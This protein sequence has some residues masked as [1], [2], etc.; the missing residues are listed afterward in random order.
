VNCGSVSYFLRP[1]HHLFVQR[2]AISKNEAPSMAIVGTSRFRSRNR[3]RIS[4]LVSAISRQ[5]WHAAPWGGTIRRCAHRAHDR[6]TRD[7][8][9]RLLRVPAHRG[10]WR[11]KRGTVKEQGISRNPAIRC[12]FGAP[13]ASEFNS[14]EVNSLRNGTG[15]FRTRIRENFSMNR[16]F[17][18]RNAWISNF[19]QPPRSGLIEQGLA[20][21]AR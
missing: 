9:S 3:F 13:S 11:A 18:T 14:L 7:R 20:G 2:V 1:A 16:E 21:P 17:S 4:Q 6:R 15:N 19:E 12:D 5:P 8:S 10:E